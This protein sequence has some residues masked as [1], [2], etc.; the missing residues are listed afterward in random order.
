MTYQRAD[1]RFR[2]RWVANFQFGGFFS[3]PGRKFAR[4]I[5]RHENTLDRHADLP[6]V[7]KATLEYGAQCQIDVCVV[8]QDSRRGTAML[9]RAADTGRQL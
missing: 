1:F 5:R 3:Q 7:V 2:E 8:G 6:G 4:S 9:Q